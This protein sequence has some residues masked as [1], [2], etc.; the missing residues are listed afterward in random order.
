MVLDLDPE[1]KRLVVSQRAANP[2][3]EADI[4]KTGT[5]HEGIVLRGFLPLPAG[6]QIP[7][8]RGSLE[9]AIVR[10]ARQILAGVEYH[11]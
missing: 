3:V 11:K 6:L 4:Y 1:R 10:P 8:S 9:P 2:K 5:V 7:L